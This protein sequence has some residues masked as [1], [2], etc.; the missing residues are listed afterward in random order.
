MHCRIGF[1]QNA[2]FV[3]C[4]D[5]SATINIAGKDKNRS[6]LTNGDLLNVG[7]VGFTVT[8]PQPAKPAK[9]FDIEFDDA[10][11]VD[12]ADEATDGKAQPPQDLVDQGSVDSQTDP[13]P[14]VRSIDF[15][16]TP[17]SSR[18]SPENEQEPDAA[19]KSEVTSA[20][21]ATPAPTAT[22]ESNER[23][24]SREASD[25]RPVFEFD[26][27]EPD[28]IKLTE[29][30]LDAI[31]NM[32]ANSLVLQDFDSMVAETFPDELRKQPSP[33]DAA[34]TELFDTQTTEPTLGAEDFIPHG[35]D[36]GKCCRWTGSSVLPAVEFIQQR[37]PSLNC[38]EIGEHVNLAS[39]S[40]TD[41]S[42]AV[43]DKDGPKIFL[44]TEK[45][46]IKLS[47]FFAAKRWNERLGHPQ[48]LSMF[49]TLL[50]AKSIRRLFE[51]IDACVLIQ[52][53][54]LELVRFNRKLVKQA[55]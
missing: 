28:D 16:D 19:P 54:D 26:S 5:A 1:L 35:T 6:R 4:F 51:Q 55:E 46:S 33:S 24:R 42:Q 3:E 41:I 22:S 21:D 44:L 10:D 20:S 36:T 12:S 15:A 45:S 31:E 39:C 18:P 37:R 48:A 49:L 8:I 7:D 29:E 43:A 53:S 32:N 9:V 30:D 52:K 2:G 27:V 17:P 13:S 34:K 14:V 23:K 47:S 11:T 40:F 25:H 38:F 50:P